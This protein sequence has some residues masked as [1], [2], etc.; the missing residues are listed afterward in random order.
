MAGPVLEAKNLTK[1]FP[2]K[3]GIFS[4]QVAVVRAVD[5]ISF[6]IDAGK[7]LGL[8]GESGCGKTTTAK[9]VLLL[10][11][12]TGGVMSFEGR[13]LQ[14]LDGGSLRAYRRSVQAVFQDPYASLNPRMRVGKI[15]IEPLTTNESL[16]SAEVKKRI[17]RLLELVGLPERAADLFP[18]E[19]SGGQRQRIALAGSIA[20]TTQV[21]MQAASVTE[22]ELTLT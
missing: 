17:S 15:I 10:E 16:P 14:A 2:V 4:R 5:D 21:V 9:M 11:Q 18:H 8:V 7:T 3:R 20:L 6:S 1:H 19:F 12:P 22:I 13:D